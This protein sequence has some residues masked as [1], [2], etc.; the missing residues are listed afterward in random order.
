MIH[1][2]LHPEQSNSWI[3]EDLGCTKDTVIAVRE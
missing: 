1:L 2:K 3:A